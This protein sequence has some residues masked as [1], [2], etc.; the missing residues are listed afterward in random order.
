MIAFT[1]VSYIF[2]CILCIHFNRVLSGFFHG[3]KG[4]RQGDPISPLLFIL[5]MEYFTRLM[6][7]MSK[8]SEFKFHYRCASLDLHHLIFADDLMFFSKG[9]VK[10]V[11]LLK[12]TLKA[13][14]ESS[15]LEASDEKTAKYFSNVTDDIQ[16]SIL[17]ITGFKI[18]EL[19]FR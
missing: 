1:S 5:A 9:D 16:H 18:G 4:R 7:K 15:R 2:C 14:A 3:E 17:Q 19:P 12:R 8:R 11:V 6:Q 13:F 10:Y